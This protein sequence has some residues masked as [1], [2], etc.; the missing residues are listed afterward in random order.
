MMTSSGFSSASRRGR[1]GR[2]EHADPVKT[3]VLLARVVV[4]ESHRLVPEPAA[5]QHL[6]DDELAGVARAHD[7]DLLTARDEAA[8]AGSL[9]QRPH[10]EPDARHEREDEHQVDGD[11]PSRQAPAVDRVP[12]VEDEHG[13]G[14][15]RDDRQEGPPHVSDG[16]VA[17]P[18]LVEPE[19]DEHGHLHRHDRDEDVQ[20]EELVVAGRNALVE[21]HV[22]GDVPGDRDEARVGDD[23]PDAVAAEEPH[24]PAPTPTAERMVSTTCSCCSA[25]IPAQRGSAIVSRPAR[26]DSGRLP[27][28]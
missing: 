15:R 23:L 6:A 18:V 16:H 11:D 13:G 4:D 19:G 27:G 22:E 28:S 9:D 1:C 14:G 2:P 5:L 20:P 17:P 8:P 3:H 7:E 26:S 25:A 12:E 21:A 24:A 10:Q